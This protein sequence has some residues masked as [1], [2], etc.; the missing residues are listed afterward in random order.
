MDTWMIYTGKGTP[1][2][3]INNLPTPP[4]WRK[5]DD[6]DTERQAKELDHQTTGHFNKE[7]D[8]HLKHKLGILQGQT[9]QSSESEIQLINTALFLR[10]PLLVTGQP[11][12]GKSSLAYAVAYELRLG[13]V[14]HWPITSRS[15]L[16]EGLYHY[17]AIGRLQDSNLEQKTS[18]KPPSN[19]RSK[20]TALE[21]TTPEQHISNIG[22]FIRLGPLGTALLPSLRPRVLLIDEI[23]KSDI[24]L[25]NDLLNIFENGYFE[26]PEL[27]R[28]E[29]TSPR[30]SVLSDDGREV[31]IEHGRIRCHAFPLVVLTSNGER[32]LPPPFLRRCIRLNIQ[33]PDKEKLQGIVNAHFKEY[34]E[35]QKSIK[36]LIDRFLEHREKG[37]KML[38]NDQ[39]LNAIY[40]TTQGIKLQEKG[41]I[42]EAVFKSLNAS[43]I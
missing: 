25:P 36:N 5:F 38:A 9:F 6:E 37:K 40:L 4:P 11:G 13:S 19:K 34:A 39:L 32:E 2:D 14:L 8:I 30:V 42:I 3:G 27:R 21:Q 20:D 18:Q 17:D 1:H 35:H 33:K 10:R 41:E 7:S 26:I 31:T 24:D 28:I 23:D 29:K 43:G 22:K 16:L 15:T 12:T